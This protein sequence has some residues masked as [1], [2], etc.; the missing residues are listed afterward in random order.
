MPNLWSRLI[1]R[2]VTLLTLLTLT[3]GAYAQ[4]A[5]WV[6]ADTSDDYVGQRLA[7][8]LKE[9]V[10]G[11]SA[12]KVVDRPQDG[13]IYVRM[14]TMNPDKSNGGNLRTT[15]SITWTV[16]TLH[17]TPVEM[18]LTSTVGICGSDR[19][20]S[21]A[22]NL[23]ATTDEQASQVRRWVQNAVDSSKSKR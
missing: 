15:Y 8:A 20:N 10:R 6:D 7:F 9:A 4:T 16:Q 5:I 2:V 18:Y 1:S 21:C 17:S 12:M 3:A 19:V 23:A 11:S 14:L 22:Q 13:S